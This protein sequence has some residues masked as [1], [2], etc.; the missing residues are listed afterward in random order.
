MNEQKNVKGGILSTVL[1]Q[2]RQPR[3]ECILVPEKDFL[4][5]TDDPKESADTDTS[6]FMVPELSAPPVLAAP[7]LRE[8]GRGVLVPEAGSASRF[9][10]NPSLEN[11]QCFTYVVS[12]CYC[13]MRVP[14]VRTTI[15]QKE[16]SFLE[17]IARI[18]YVMYKST[19][20]D[21]II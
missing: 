21:D 7:S 9:W 10:K 5:L 3:D 18:I 1:I 12:V 17:I 4:W 14:S 16:E 15:E 6:D 13:F 19:V 11:N 2:G 20:E 8:G